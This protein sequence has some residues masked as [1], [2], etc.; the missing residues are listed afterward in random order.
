EI[1]ILKKK[2]YLLH[3]CQIYDSRVGQ[4]ITELFP[5]FENF[6]VVARS[7]E[8]CP[9][10]GNRLTPYNMGLITQTEKSYCTLYSGI[11]CRNVNRNLYTFKRDLTPVKVLNHQK[12]PK[13]FSK[14][15]SIKP[16][17]DSSASHQSVDATLQN[18][19]SRI[20]LCRYTIRRYM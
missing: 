3:T 6:S 20:N 16:I 2:Q 12:G 1:C 17:V 7:L 15:G 18:K 19:A 8:L 4:S 9:V 11:T 10:Y 14:S 5:F 13:V